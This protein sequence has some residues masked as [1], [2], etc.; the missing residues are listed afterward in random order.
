MAQGHYICVCKTDNGW[1]GVPHFH[2]ISQHCGEVWVVI[3]R[4]TVNVFLAFQGQYDGVKKPM[5][6]YHIKVVGFDQRVSVSIKGYHSRK[7]WII[8]TTHQL[9]QK[10]EY[11]H[12][13]LDR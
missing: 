10:W 2:S 6:E 5:P 11:F 4:H 3:F 12:T 7:K 13:F 9:Q 8:C 1:T